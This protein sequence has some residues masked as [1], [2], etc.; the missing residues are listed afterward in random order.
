MKGKGFTLI[1]LLVV[2]AIIA[3][4]MGVLMP[5]LQVAKDHAQRIQCQSNAKTLAMAWFMYQGDNEGKLVSALTPIMDDTS[6][7][8]QT[9]WVR[10]ANKWDTDATIEE[11]EVAMKAGALWRYTGENL[12]VYRCPA[13][14]RI[15]LARLATARSYSIPDGANGEGYPPG[16]AV[17]AK[18]YGELRQPSMKYI[19]I[20]DFDDRGDNQNSW[21]LNFPTGFVDPVAI[22]HHNN[23][24]FAFADSHSE[25]HRWRDPDFINWCDECLGAAMYREGDFTFNHSSA[26]AAND[27]RFLADGFPCRSHR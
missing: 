24:T 15:K 21:D 1:E 18:R 6:P 2:I 27:Y 14:R 22:W 25:M 8:A 20:E 11:K 12:K 4:L 19:F 13:D 3:V 10:L 5:A 26:D 23:S 17:V 16:A 7:A 9:A